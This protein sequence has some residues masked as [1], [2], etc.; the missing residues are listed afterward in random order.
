MK[1]FFITG[2]DT[3]VGKTVIASG[4]L[5]AANA[6]GMRSLALK[7]V[8]AGCIDNGQGLRN[9]DALLLQQTASIA[10]PY[11]QIN[12]VALAPAIAPHIAAQQAGITLSAAALVTH[13]DTVLAQ[14]VDIAVIEGAGGWRVPL[15]AHETLA[16]VAKALARPIIL[17]VSMRLGCI[18]HTLLTAEAIVND[19][20]LLAGWVANID[21]MTVYKDN[22]ESI[23]ARLPA[24]CLGEVP[25]LPQRGGSIDPQCVAQYLDLDRLVS[26]F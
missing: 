13:C 15:N 2:T 21:S 9:E 12:P 18:N 22:V 16:D 1:A 7:P 24:P 4:L 3:G 19:G 25:M 17:V 6:R 8:A 10:L 26:S 5:A 14:P 20:L 23:A 11:Q